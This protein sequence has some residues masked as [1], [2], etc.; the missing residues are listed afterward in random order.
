MCIRFDK[1]D[2]F[3]RVNDR[4]KY[5]VFF[6]SEK[7]GFIYNRIR[8]KKVALHMFF[9]HNYAKIKAYSYDYLPLEKALNLHNF[10]IHVKS[11][12]NKNQNYY[13]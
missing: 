4:T 12:F 1:L 5:L 3:I 2:R 6:G 7:Y 10:I 11:A 8:Q 9:S 13:Y